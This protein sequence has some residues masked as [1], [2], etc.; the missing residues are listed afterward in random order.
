MQYLEC[1][2]CKAKVI[3]FNNPAPTVDVIIYDPTLGVVLI[4]RKFEPLGFALPGGFIEVGETAESAAVR[5]AKE[6]T[7]L[8]IVLGKLFGV[9]SDPKRDARRHT[10]SV[11]YLATTENPQVVQGGDDAL[12]ATWFALDSLPTLAFDH[13][14]I[15]QQF[16]QSLAN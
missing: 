13:G 3:K 1:P 2:L 11:V 14:E 6:E 7:G 5:E 4:E 8:D 10:I 15:L 16:K 12:T 9:Y